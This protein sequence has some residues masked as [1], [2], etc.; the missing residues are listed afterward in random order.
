MIP[1]T[2]IESHV[3]LPAWKPGPGWGPRSCFV[4]RC[5]WNEG[6]DM[7]LHGA[8]GSS[9]QRTQDALPGEAQPP[10]PRVSWFPLVFLGLWPHHSSLC[11]Q[12][13]ASFS[14]LYVCLLLSLSL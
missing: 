4:R 14:S 9:W 5:V 11:L 1:G 7:R 2:G 13:H 8:V 3:G 12:L 10:D 6:Q